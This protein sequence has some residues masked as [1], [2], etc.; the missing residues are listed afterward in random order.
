M[1][2]YPQTSGMGELKAFLESGQLGNLS[3]RPSL[4]ELYQYMGQATAED[5]DVNVVPESNFIRLYYENFEVRYINE[6][7]YQLAIYFKNIEKTDVSTESSKPLGILWYS[8]VSK[9]NFDEI[10]QF[11]KFNNIGCR[12]VVFSLPEEDAGLVIEVITTGI[13]ISFENRSKIDCIHYTPSQPGKFE[14][15]PL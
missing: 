5:R 10:V 2:Q 8:T 1:T 4:E 11:L 12:Q 14:Y 15:L 9:M 3:N 13:W 6:T 7:F